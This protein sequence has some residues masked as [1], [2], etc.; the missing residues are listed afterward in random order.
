MAE[1]NDI[2][3]ERSL[4]LA[5]NIPL[6]IR[7][8]HPDATAEALSRLCGSKI[9]VDVT[10]TDGVVTD[11]GQTIKA[12]LLGQTAAAVMGHQII[13]KTAAEIRGIGQIMRKMLKQGGPVPDGVWADLGVLEAVRDYPQRHTSTLLVFDAVE[14]AIARIEAGKSCPGAPATS[15]A[16]NS[17]G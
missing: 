2:Y 13:G 3:S 12:C 9:V 14:D 8:E 7:L 6:T 5:A 4:A 10:M 11:Y 16:I 1:L 15:P 17:A